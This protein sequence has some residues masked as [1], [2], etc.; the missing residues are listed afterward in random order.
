MTLAGLTVVRW[1]RGGWSRPPFAGGV[2]LV[3]GMTLLAG[4]YVA[5]IGK[6]T[7]K[8]TG[9]QLIEQMQ[10]K[11]GKPTYFDGSS[12]GAGNVPLASWWNAAEAGDQSRAMWA[13]QAVAS[14]YWKTAHYS[15]V[16]F[17]AIGLFAIRK[18]FKDPGV[19]L[20]L[21]VAIVHVSVLWWLAWRIGYVS[22]RHT[23]LTVMISCV[24]A[25]S[26]FPA[27][28]I[29][30]VQAWHTRTLARTGLRVFAPVA[31]KYRARWM[32]HVL[33]SASPWI[34]GT[35]WTLL[36][37]APA[38]P[39]DF[40]S[41]HADRA[42]HKYA[43]EWLAKEGDPNIGLIDAFG[44]AEWYA[45]RSLREQPTPNPWDGNPWYVIYEPNAK[46][47]H[48]RLE[49]YAYA[50]MMME[51]KAVQVYQYPSDVPPDEIKVAVYLYTPV[52][53]RRHWSSRSAPSLRFTSASP[54]NAARPMTEYC[55]S[56]RRNSLAMTRTSSTGRVPPCQSPC[57]AMTGRPVLG[58]FLVRQP[59][60]GEVRRVRPIFAAVA[61][62]VEQP[63]FQVGV[64]GP[65]FIRRPR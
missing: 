24:L 21:V 42:G 41:L 7:N 4:P 35:I 27:L 47:P 52:K 10:G 3:I 23:L 48:S 57:L 64:Q 54:S 11:D 39:R 63:R 20:L 45:G 18:R 25:A 5:L 12:R 37:L 16:I 62:E 33:R 8:P 53:K 9:N 22:Q 29:W 14:E 65:E 28:G 2:G 19:A 43:G 36:L 26:A 55:G 56:S 58:S 40:Y 61:A 44:W 46:S 49:Y 38:L 13:I 59:A 32:I 1:R 34:L 51:W 17:A 31:G 50:K 60:Q 30:A 6:L 15:L